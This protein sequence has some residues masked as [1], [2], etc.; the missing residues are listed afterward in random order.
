M[1]VIVWWSLRAWKGEGEKTDG[2]THGRS[3]P[4]RTV[5]GVCEPVESDLEMR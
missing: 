2:E 1:L 3:D 5:H 4:E